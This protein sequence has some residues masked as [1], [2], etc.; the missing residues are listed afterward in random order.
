MRRLV[1][2]PVSLTL[3]LTPFLTLLFWLLNCGRW[4]GPEER[5]ITLEE[6]TW[7][8][9]QGLELGE[10]QEIESKGDLDIGGDKTFHCR[11]NWE[12]QYCSIYRVHPLRVPWLW[13]LKTDHICGLHPSAEGAGSGWGENSRKLGGEELWTPGVWI[14]EATILLSPLI[15]SL[16]RVSGCWKMG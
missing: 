9:S 8:H 10:N 3:E 14:V 11:L 1:L 13:T 15:P 5:W 2:E 16:P 4:L 6:K 7:T 12:L